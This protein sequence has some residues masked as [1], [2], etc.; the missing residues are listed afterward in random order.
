MKEVA[1]LL[2]DMLS[3]NIIKAY[4]VFGAIAQ[5]RYSEAVATMD[6]DVLNVQGQRPETKPDI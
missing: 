2:S 5:M 6:A 1:Q 3:A 4:A